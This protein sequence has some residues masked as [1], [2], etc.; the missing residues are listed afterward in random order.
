MTKPGLV[1]LKM[2]EYKIMFVS[3]LDL[4]NS[5]KFEDKFKTHSQKWQMTGLS[6]TFNV[7]I[8]DCDEVIFHISGLGSFHTFSMFTRTA[9]TTED[10][11]F[12]TGEIH[13][14]NKA[15]LKSTLPYH[16][17]LK[18]HPYHASQSWEFS[19]SISPY[20]DS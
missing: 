2:R 11:S 4:W 16:L 18:I 7:V 6:K 13:N 5:K 1:G 14:R 12:L 19:Y 3:V 15:I 17:E 20:D 10:I 9:A 8:D